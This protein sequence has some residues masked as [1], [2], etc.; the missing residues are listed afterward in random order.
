MHWTDLKPGDVFKDGSYTIYGKPNYNAVTRIS[1][2]PSPGLYVVFVDPDDFNQKRVSHDHEFFL[3]DFDLEKRGDIR[4]AGT[5][6]VQ[7]N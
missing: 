7:L 3:W 1:D 6:T 5:S 2:G 4:K